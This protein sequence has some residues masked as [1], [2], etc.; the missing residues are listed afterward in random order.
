MTL[1]FFIGGCTYAEISAFR[2]LSEAN[3]SNIIS[4]SINL[5]LDSINVTSFYLFYLFLKKLIGPS[6]FI[7]ATTCLINGKNLI[8]S[9]EN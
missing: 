5:Y 6:E 8:S 2:F 3:D 4:I 1:V 9:L 7:V